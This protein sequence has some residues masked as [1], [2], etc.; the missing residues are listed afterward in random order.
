MPKGR[1][2]R[3]RM[4]APWWAAAILALAWLLFSSVAD[5]ATAP[6]APAPES[7][8]RS[9]PAKNVLS[10]LRAIGDGILDANVNYEYP[11]KDAIAAH[12]AIESGTTLGATVLIP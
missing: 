2:L 1:P 8:L 6:P 12:R 10:P 7:A 9:E 5:A 3:K 11:L 4:P